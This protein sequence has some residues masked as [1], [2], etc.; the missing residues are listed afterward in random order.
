MKVSQSGQASSQD[1]AQLVPLSNSAHQLAKDD[2][3]VPREHPLKGA[4]SAQ[5]LH[6]AKNFPPINGF[7]KSQ[8]DSLANWFHHQCGLRRL[9]VTTGRPKTTEAAKVETTTQV[10]VKTVVPEG[11]TDSSVNLAAM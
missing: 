6:S 9:A 1:E 3:K 8:L 11:S 4:R 2:A 5:I 7:Q 10:E